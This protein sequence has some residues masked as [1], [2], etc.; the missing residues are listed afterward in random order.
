MTMYRNSDSADGHTTTLRPGP[1][2][3]RKAWFGPRSRLA[4]VLAVVASASLFL[5]ACATGGEQPVAEHPP[6]HL[7]GTVSL[8]HHW[9]DREA[10]VWKHAVDRFE[11]EYPDVTVEI[12]SNQQD[13]KTAR[14]LATGGDVDVLMVSANATLGSTCKAM[15]D[16]KPY[17]KRDSVSLSQFEKPFA[18]MTSYQGRRCALP[19]VADSHGLF[20]NKDL[21]AKAGYDHPPKTLSQL[22]KMTLKLTTY[23]QDGSIKTL[24]FD[25]LIGSGAVT[26]VTLSSATGAR[27]LKDGQPATNS[28]SWRKL[29]RWQKSLVD[30]IGYKKLKEFTAGLG[31]QYSANNPFQ[32]GKVAMA[33]DG[34]YRVAFIE[35]QASK[36]HYG[37]APFPV[38]PGTKARYG[39]SAMAGPSIGIRS[40]S[41]HQELAW[42]LVKFLTTDTH[43]AVDVANGLRNIP[44]LKAAASSDRLETSKQYGTFIQVARNEH[45]RAVPPTSIGS[46]LTDALGD[47][48]ETY[49]AG[50]GHGLSGG[51]DHVTENIEK[52]MRLREAK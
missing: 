23:H 6:K 51:L 9:S 48:W 7:S 44:A 32:K 13:D 31:D 22:K 4:A 17:M 50:S 41:K 35:D 19:T 5:A 10:T 29:L 49:Q 24:G 21:F 11:A 8:W 43:T 20:Y 15:T 36:L 3:K 47:Y 40:G 26:P 18:Q 25:P 39:S 52:R 1:R 27:F 34:E 2:G 16:L 42:A 38:L 45:S 46:T 33:V 37:T 14:V 30:K 12:H 28:K